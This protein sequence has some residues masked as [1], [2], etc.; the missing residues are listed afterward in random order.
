M[1]AGG[2]GAAGG[3]H[4]VQ[5]TISLLSRSLDDASSAVARARGR[6]GGVGRGQKRAR[7][8]GGW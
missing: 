1:T 7:G 3:G 5:D 2:E 8:D 6:S 4:P